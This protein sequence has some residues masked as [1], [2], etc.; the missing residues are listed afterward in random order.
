VRREQK[1]A[2][3]SA[4]VVAT[5]LVET[6]DIEESSD[7]PYSQIG[8]ESVPESGGG[9]E[10]IS[11]VESVVSEDDLDSVLG[12]DQY[13][14]S[15]TV[16]VISE[17]DLDSHLGLN[18]FALP[19]PVVDDVSANSSQ[20]GGSDVTEDIL[21]SR[22]VQVEEELLPSQDIEGSSDEPCSQIESEPVPEVGG[23]TESVEA[24]ETVAAR[25]SPPVKIGSTTA[26]LL[27]RYDADTA[28]QVLE[29]LR[30]AGYKEADWLL[31]L[32]VMEADGA[33]EALVVATAE[34]SRAQERA[35]Q[36]D[37]IERDLQ[38]DTSSD[39]LDAKAT[40][41]HAAASKQHQSA[42]TKRVSKKVANKKHL[43]VTNEFTEKER[44]Q[45]LR[46]ERKAKAEMEARLHAEAKISEIL[47]AQRVQQASEAT[48]LAGMREEQEQLRAEVTLA[49][50]ALQEQER[51]R[52]RER[53]A[54]LDAMEQRLND[55][56][57]EMRSRFDA[58]LQEERHSGSR[59]WQGV[60][61]VPMASIPSTPITSAHTGGLQN[62][63]GSVSEMQ[64]MMMMQQ[65][66]QMLTLMQQQSSAA[67]HSSTAPSFDTEAATQ[68]EILAIRAELRAAIQQQE[69]HSSKEQLQ[70]AQERISLEVERERRRGEEMMTLRAEIATWKA[71]LEE[72]T[73]VVLTE[74]REAR[75]YTEDQNRQL[76]EDIL[77]IPRVDQQ[78]SHGSFS[79][80]TVESLMRSVM[81]ARQLDSTAA[82][83][84]CPGA[85]SSSAPQATVVTQVQQHLATAAELV[86]TAEQLR[87]TADATAAD[88]R[89]LRATSAADLR[90]S[91]TPHAAY[92]SSGTPA[93]PVFVPPLATM[94]GLRAVTPPDAGEETRARSSD[95]LA[96]L[97]DSIL[98]V[99][100]E[101]SQ[102][103]QPQSP[104]EMYQD[105]HNPWARQM[106]SD[107]EMATEASATATSA[108]VP[109]R[110]L[111]RLASPPLRVQPAWVDERDGVDQPSQAS[112]SRS[113]A[114]SGDRSEQFARVG[115]AN[116]APLLDSHQDDARYKSVDLSNRF[117]GEQMMQQRTADSNAEGDAAASKGAGALFVQVSSIDKVTSWLTSSPT[118][119]ESRAYDGPTR[120]DA[121][122]HR[123][124]P[125]RHRRQPAEP[126]PAAAPAA[127]SGWTVPAST[128]QTRP[129]SR[130][131]SPHAD[132]GDGDGDGVYTAVP[133]AAAWAAPRRS[134]DQAGDTRG[135]S[136]GQSRG[137]RS[138]REGRSADRTGR[139][140]RRAGSRGRRDGRRDRNLRPLDGAAGPA[141]PA[142]PAGGR[143][144]G[145][146]P[147]GGRPT[148]APQRTGSAGDAQHR[149]YGGFA[150][151]VLEGAETASAEIYPSTL[152]LHPRLPADTVRAS[153]QLVVEEADVDYTALE[154]RW[155]AAP[156]GGPQ[157]DRGAGEAVGADGG[158]GE[159]MPA[160]EDER[161]VF[162]E[163]SMAMASALLARNEPAAAA[164]RVLM[165]ARAVAA[166]A[167]VEAVRL[168]LLPPLHNALS[169][170]MRRLGRPQEAER[171]LREAGRLNVR[172]RG[173]LTAGA[174]DG[175]AEGVDGG[176]GEVEAQLQQATVVEANTALN[177]CAVLSQL[178]R[179]PAALEAAA[180][181]AALLRSV[182]LDRVGQPSAGA[183]AGEH[184][185]LSSDRGGSQ[186]AIAA[187][188]AMM[189]QM[190][191]HNLQVC[192]ESR[193]KR[194]GQAK[195]RYQ[196]QA[197]SAPAAVAR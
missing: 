85:P 181:A 166:E 27:E 55:K 180:A 17:D 21:S 128:R 43:A 121:N 191:E 12:L 103:A 25:H 155:A 193:G 13:A 9:T 64:Q 144:A 109:A 72:Q 113:S 45:R 195:R 134:A 163:R 167:A 15:V 142:G 78:A 69:L 59:Q 14:N 150:E 194:K 56:D 196:R 106:Q 102:S 140:A 164:L 5:E 46:I 151:E 136:P 129:S 112:S 34:D 99:G 188:V 58:R 159:G 28:E 126:A 2:R 149:I 115:E 135:Q 54:Q 71:S 97:L 186:A 95:R 127:R 39:K 116:A 4:G 107:T 79:S 10:S 32:K 187:Q 156:R 47:E 122:E 176:G 11:L 80:A 38:G 16:S 40:F 35:A 52:I 42:S 83:P 1:L 124:R 63:M 158:G 133:A 137:Q 170:C 90:G 8:T 118:P 41:D 67:P 89:E 125:R 161:V 53:E 68:T 36:L 114:Y 153:R 179:H 138:K 74:A 31:E 189:L 117:A 70:F 174:V 183:A 20:H 23:G 162:V 178:G 152:S 192:G 77:R 197:Q 120:S 182:D 6:I 66:Q 7:E 146:A 22:S 82:T 88:L 171:Q 65:Q 147:V 141:G 145:P 139:R 61:P 96:E 50:V 154:A 104:Q 33:L 173:L 185:P 49:H 18:Q 130:A 62:S 93:R 108:M 184:P 73:N 160:L 101:E 190:A 92:G 177:L 105:H 48:N 75:R 37:A 119:F 169:C 86:S 57:D 143:T 168:L 100:S 110:G 132:D 29:S 44:A 148:S 123:A 81:A 84:Q 91:S 165:R 3:Q 26:W 30:S 131:R 98:P 172:R 24:A 94:P 76:R 60:S 111:G 87:A 51:V 175:A 19:P 157:T